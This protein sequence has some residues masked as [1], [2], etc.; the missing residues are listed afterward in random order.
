MV[1]HVVKGEKWACSTLEAGKNKPSDY[2]GKTIFIKRRS[3]ENYSFSS[4]IFAMNSLG[5]KYRHGGFCIIVG[6]ACYDAINLRTCS[7][8]N[9]YSILVG[10]VVWNGNL[11]QES[12]IRFF[13]CM[14]KGKTEFFQSRPH[15]FCQ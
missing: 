6:V 13:I 5:C 3:F 11:A 1:K 9:H 12:I 4:L 2:I 10:G 8:G 7:R 14:D 15:L